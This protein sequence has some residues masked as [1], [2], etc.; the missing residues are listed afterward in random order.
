MDGR[1]DGHQAHH[2]IPQTFRS[3]DKSVCCD[4][5]SEPSQRGSSDK[6]SQHMGSMRNKK[7]YPLII[8]KYS[9]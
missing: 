3:G 8:I 7:T 4:P 6:W 1:T 2:Y 5:L 9:L